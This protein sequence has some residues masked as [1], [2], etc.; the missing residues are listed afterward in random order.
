MLIT[1]R[2][3]PSSK[4][5]GRVCGYRVTLRARPQPRPRAL[6]A[7]PHPQ[8]LAG[9]ASCGGFWV[10]PLPCSADRSFV[11]LSF[12]TRRDA[13]APPADKASAAEAAC[14]PAR[15]VALALSSCKQAHCRAAR[16][17]CLPAGGGSPAARPPCATGRP[18]SPARGGPSAAPPLSRHPLLPRTRHNRGG[19]ALGSCGWRR[20][21][22]RRE[23]HGDRRG[24]RG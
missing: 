12:T 21:C 9:A 10:P 15:T 13:P 20:W 2:S 5:V 19:G 24:G 3:L 1:G 7:R 14:T 8:G 6:P 23:C 16:L 22:F 17:P 4:L 11:H 18:H